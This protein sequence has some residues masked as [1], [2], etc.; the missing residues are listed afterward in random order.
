MLVLFQEGIPNIFIP[1]LTRRGMRVVRFPTAPAM[2]EAVFQQNS[3]AEAIFFRANFSFGAGVLALLPKLTLAALV[4]TGTDNVDQAAIAVRGVHLTT[5]EGANAQAVFD[6]VIQALLLG[7]FEPAKHSV[8]V[9]GAGRIG[10][11]LLRFFA[12]VGVRTAFYD[13]FLNPPGSL[14]DVLQCDF[15]TFHTPLT[16]GG[17]GAVADTYQPL[18]IAD[19]MSSLPQPLSHETNHA[20]AGMLNAG[21]FSGA[22]HG[23]KIIQ[24]SRGGIWDRPFYDDLPKSAAVWLLAQDVYPN[25][26]PAAHDLKVAAYSTPHIAGYSTRGRLGGIVKGI[27]AL[28]PDFSAAGILPQGRAW[29]LENDAKALSAGV[30]R[31]SALRD[32]YPWRKQFH[33]WDHVERRAYRQRFQ[34]LPD[35]FFEALFS[36]DGTG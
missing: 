15:V 31:F 27:Q 6:Y 32:G 36:F 1:E 3:G 7:G 20:T 11:R 5:A 14:P 13:P 18:A 10:S 16:H 35:A 17:V 26:P 34:S 12:S 30:G 9:V 4:S 33:E 8:G 2:A 25:E 22:R 28:V 21:Y 19:G 24:A 23:L 29:L